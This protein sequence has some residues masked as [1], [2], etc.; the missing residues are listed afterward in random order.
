MIEKN[1]DSGDLELPS[2]KRFGLTF[3]AIF[4]T[5]CLFFL[6]LDS[7]TMAWLFGIVML[8]FFILS[9][10]LSFMLSRVNKIWVKIGYVISSITT[11]IILGFIFFLIF[12]PIA[13]LMRVSRR[14]EL[15]LSDKTKF[16]TYWKAR[17]ESVSPSNSFK[18]QF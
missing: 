10:L 15:R 8:L 12:T 17:D 11:P 18:N 1:I 7:P 5:A 4:G 3:T 9:Y 2:N 13:V 6:Y 16:R 14:D